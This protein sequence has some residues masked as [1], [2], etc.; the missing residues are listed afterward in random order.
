M[1]L[2]REIVQQALA[3]SCL[4]IEAEEQL[5]QLLAQKYDSQDLRAFMQLQQATMS[6]LVKQE[7]REL[8]YSS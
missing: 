7:S 2:I 6:G 5:R 8:L 3:S 4:T 1:P